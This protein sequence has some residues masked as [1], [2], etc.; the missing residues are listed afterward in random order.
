MSRC[1]QKAPTMFGTN[2]RADRSPGR[3]AS[4]AMFLSESLCDSV[5]ECRLVAGVEGAELA[6]DERLLKGSEDRLDGGGLE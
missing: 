2:K 6:N 3:L 5:P 4:G 1:N